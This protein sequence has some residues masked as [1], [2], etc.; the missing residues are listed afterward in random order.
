[1]SD[2]RGAAARVVVVGDALIDE[3]RTDAGSSEHVGG[4]ALNVAIGMSLLGVPSTLVAMVG[5]DDDGTRIRD[6]LSRHRIPLLA[7][8]TPFG[9]GRATSTRVDGEPMYWFNAAAMH[10]ALDFGGATGR[11]LRLAS[12]VVLSGFPFDDEGQVDALESAL[13]GRNSIVLIDP[14][15][16]LG[17]IRD[18]TA[19]RR[20]VERVSARAFLVKFSDEDAN[21]FELPPEVAVQRLLARGATN[22]LATHGAGGASLLRRDGAPIS[23]PIAA[24]P[25]EVVDTMGAGDSVLAT[26]SARLAAIG[27]APTEAQWAALLD[28]AMRVAAATCREPGA[29]LRMPRR[30]SRTV[31]ADVP[32]SHSHTLP[33]GTLPALERQPAGQQHVRRGERPPHPGHDLRA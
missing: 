10:R 7:T 30:S 13:A 22:V 12:M 16:R 32:P 14:N 4:S 19:F 20:N 1:M 25:D 26:V 23:A 27:A 31:T 21:L 3:L 29:L 15:P 9:T 24:L 33:V 11:A 6:T 28:E 17:L 5:A 18:L 2:E 8:A